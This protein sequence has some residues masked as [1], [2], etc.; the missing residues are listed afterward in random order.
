MRAVR[1]SEEEAR[2]AVRAARSYS[3]ALRKLGYRVAGGNHA[4]LKKYAQ[5]W[6]ISTD[7]FDTSWASRIPR[8]RGRIPMSAILVEQSTYSRAHLKDR[9]FEEGL[10]QRACELCGQDESWRGERMALILDHING[11]GDDNRLENLRIVCPNCAATFATHCGRKN[12]LAGEERDCKRCG[13]PF[14]VKYATHRYCCHF[15]GSRASLKHKGVPRP[16]RRKVDRPSPEQLQADLEELGYAGTGRKY[17]VS[18]NAVRKWVG[19]YGFEAS[20]GQ[21]DSG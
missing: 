6:G 14:R 9:L 21:E 18:D 12:S 11:V 2:E 10:K 17:G 1:F 3:E 7:H 13:R 15:C 8:R 5:A 16:E 20:R 4:T 19:W